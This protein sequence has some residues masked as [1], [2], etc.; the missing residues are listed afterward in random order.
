[1]YEYVHR[2]LF[3][4]FHGFNDGDDHLVVMHTCHNRL[5]MNPLHLC[6]GSR[7]HNRVMMH[8]P[9]L[10]PSSSS[11]DSLCAIEKD[12]LAIEAVREHLLFELGIRKSE[13]VGAIS[14][15]KHLGIL[16]DES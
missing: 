3:W 13:P 11:L 10:V 4:A 2:L 9:S 6:L 16:E 12:G 8:W 1:V 7:S 15:L 5:C 14:F